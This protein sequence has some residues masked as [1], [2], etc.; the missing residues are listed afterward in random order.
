MKLL[1]T[2]ISSKFKIKAGAEL[3]QAQLP[4]EIRLYLL[5]TNYIWSISSCITTIPDVCVDGGCG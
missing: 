5:S 1:A 3:G 4:A 2:V